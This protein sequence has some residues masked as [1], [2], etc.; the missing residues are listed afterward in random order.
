MPFTLPWCPTVLSRTLCPGIRNIDR[1]ERAPRVPTLAVC[2]QVRPTLHP[3]CMRH[4]HR[5]GCR[6]SGV[7]NVPQLRLRGPSQPAFA[8]ESVAC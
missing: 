3:T 7:P 2:P 8:S 4:A 1:D 5:T 6:V